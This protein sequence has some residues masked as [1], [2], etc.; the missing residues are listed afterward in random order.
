MY[1]LSIKWNLLWQLTPPQVIYPVIYIL[2]KFNNFA[3]V[4]IFKAVT[5][6]EGYKKSWNNLH[7]LH[8]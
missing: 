8:W 4:Y 1:Q 6:A 3:Y 7:V 2:R 5:F